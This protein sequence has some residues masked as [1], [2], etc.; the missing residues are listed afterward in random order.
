MANKS[1][2]MKTESRREYILTA[3]ILPLLVKMSIPTIIGMLVNVLYNLTDTFFI[4][5]LSNK[6]MTAAIG[7]VFS[8][9]AVVQAFGFWFGYGSGVVMSREI[10]EDNIK[11]AHYVSTVGVDFAI[12]TGVIISAICLFN[13]RNLASVLGATA[14]EELMDYTSQ[15]LR[16]IILSIPFNLYS[17]TLYNQ[18][19]LYGSVKDAMI[20][21]LCGMFLNMILDPIMIFC[22]HIGFTGAGYATMIGQTVSAVVLT[23]MSWRNGNIPIRFFN[24]H[25]NKNRVYNV[26]VGGS[27]NFARQGI[28]SF[29]LILLNV[30]CARYSENLIA[31]MTV[32]SKIMAIAFLVMIGWGQGF[33]P[34]CAMNFGA[35]QYDRVKNSYFYSVSIGTVFLTISAILIALFSPW[36]V[37]T[38]VKDKAVI[39]LGTR[40]LRIQCTSLPFMAAFAI[41]SMFMQNVG[42]YVKSLFISV[43]RQGYVYIPVLLLLPLMFGETGIYWSQPVSD[44]ISVT[45][46][47]LIVAH[48][49]RKH[50]DIFVIKRR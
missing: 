20:G 19:R 29:S 17:F 14:S 1:N 23:I 10:G 45:I 15:Y 7:I 8:F 22:F 48:Y 43:A 31:A 40:I 11:E 39:A 49:F 41:S 30:I 2:E 36:L 6:S 12:I 18:M 25:L 13:V 42:Q 27:P 4:G 47:L 34:I 16:I 26:L 28:T 50:R 3:P 32:T 21:L 35:K 37:G 38:L 5:Q 33:Q 24:L 44:F 46:A 9:M